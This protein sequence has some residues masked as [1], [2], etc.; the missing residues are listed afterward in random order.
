MNQDI[1]DSDS[2]RDD[3]PSATSMQKANRQNYSAND[4]P[5][6]SIIDVTDISI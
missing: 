2:D 5:S 6:R 3:L 4:A 1:V